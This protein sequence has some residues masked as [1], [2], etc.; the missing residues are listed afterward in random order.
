VTGR[1]RVRF[2]VAEYL[3]LLCATVDADSTAEDRADE[4]EERRRAATRDRALG[5]IH[6]S[7]TDAERAE[8]ARR[9]T[10]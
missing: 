8:V 3:A 4:P 7:L 10:S 6:G 5:K 2:T 9:L 1:P